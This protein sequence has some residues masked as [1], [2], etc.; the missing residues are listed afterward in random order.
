M[1]IVTVMKRSIFEGEHHVRPDISNEISGGDLDENIDFQRVIFKFIAHIMARAK[2]E[3]V[4]Q[5]EVEKANRRPT[6]PDPTRH[7]TPKLLF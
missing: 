7:G 2:R 1:P 5:D 6:R 4:V 3:R